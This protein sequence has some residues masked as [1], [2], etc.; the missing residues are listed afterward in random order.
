MSYPKPFSQ[1][2]PCLTCGAGLHHSP[3]RHQDW[4]AWVTRCNARPILWEP[5]VSKALEAMA[6]RKPGFGQD[7]VQGMRSRV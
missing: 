2:N 4:C 3:D 7:H 6:H 5:T 1:T